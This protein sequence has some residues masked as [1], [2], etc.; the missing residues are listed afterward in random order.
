MLHKTAHSCII[1]GMLLRFQC[2]NFRSFRDEQTI[3]LVAARTRSDE[4]DETLIET[5]IK[6]V[7]GLRCAAIYGA[8]ASGKT[9]LLKAMSSFRGTISASQKNWDETDAIPTY[10]P[11]LLEEETKRGETEY[12]ADVLIDNTRYQYGFCC[13]RDT[14]TREWLVEFGTRDRTLFRRRTDQDKVRVDFPG[15]NLTGSILENIKQLTR[16]NSLFLS[17]AAQN[18]FEPLK[19]IHAWFTERFRVVSPDDR[20]LASQTNSMFKEGK[21]SENIRLMIRSADVGVTDIEVI[22]EEYPEPTKKYIKAFLGVMKESSSTTEPF[23]EPS[24]FTHLTARLKHKGAHGEIYTFD[25]DDESAGTLRFF[26]MLGP[27]LT[28]LQDGT[29]LLIDEIESSLHP[30][31]VRALVE[32]VNSKTTNPKGAQVIFTTHSPDLLGAGLLRRDQVWF[33]EKGEDGVSSIYPLSDFK[34]RKDQ[35]LAA[36][37]LHGRFGA[38][39]FLDFPNIWS[40]LSV[41]PREDAKVGGLNSEE[42]QIA[43]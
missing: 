25:K 38:V 31:L 23:E 10:E 29:V 16:R 22:E 17:A 1:R 37:Y 5:P 24:S 20:G 33:T 12:E 42:Q 32:M 3:S 39:P 18:N 7:S 19:R 15:R 2:K 28:E 36:G 43:P 35:N 8:N 34:P 9:N 40:L 26:A 30:L 11:F 4:R 14:V 13:N 21:F 27:I 6:G 41:D